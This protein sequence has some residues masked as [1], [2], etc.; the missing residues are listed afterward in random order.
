[1]EEKKHNYLYLRLLEKKPYLPI[2]GFLEL[3]YSCNLHCLHCY[4]K[5]SENP[6]QE[7]TTVQWKNI[8]LEIKKAG[9]MYLVFTGGDPLVRH[10]FLE[11]YR[12]AKEQGF[13]VTV[14]TNGIGFTDKMIRYLAKSPPYYIDI[15][16]NGITPETYEDITQVEGAFEHVMNNVKKIKQNNIP[17]RIK[18]NCMKKNKHEIIR[19]KEFAT[20][21]LGASKGKYLFAYDVELFP[22]LSGDKTPLAQRLSADEVRDVIEQDTDMRNEYARCLGNGKPQARADAT[23]Y[24]CNAW[25]RQFFINPFGRLKFCQLTDKFSID[26]LKIPFK[27]GFFKEFPR[28]ADE[29]F[30]A[31]SAC[32]SCSLRNVCISCPAKAFL[33]TG[34]E[35]SPVSYY[36]EL[37]RRIASDMK[38]MKEGQK[39]EALIK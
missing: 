38:G 19:I 31:G 13:I 3:T 22:R 35:E 17:L 28:V 2:D 23:L 4:V 29:K 27:E 16:L 20:D 8:I 26:L 18:V 33:E 9:C 34:N 30:K 39:E 24:K 12:Y 6:A 14:F 15:T 11:L 5:G 1:M 21:L 25:K 37:S 10:D 36:C 32:R 7:L